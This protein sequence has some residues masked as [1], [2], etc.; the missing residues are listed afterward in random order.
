MTAFAKARVQ[1]QENS[2]VTFIVKA[3]IVLIV[4]YAGSK[5]LPALPTFAVGALW[6]A[7]SIVMTIGLT[8]HAV[9]RK[10]HRQYLL[11]S[12]GFVSRLINGWAFRLILAFVISAICVAGLFFEAPK[13]G[14]AEWCTV[15]L[16]I[17]VY[18]GVSTL[19]GKVIDKELEPVFQTSRK[20]LWS[21]LI[22]GALLC[23]VYAV[24]CF[25]QP[26][27]TYATAADAFL[28]A[29]QPFAQSPS[30]IMA[31]AGKLVALVDGLTVYALSRAGRF[32]HVWNRQPAR[33]LLAW[34]ARFQAS[35]PAARS[36]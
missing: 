30:A 17:P 24:I 16:A 36:N 8:Y 27:E 4:L 31:E 11:K 6:S 34:P 18:L 7:L 2:P 23:I 33:G 21:S 28:A 25:T 35:F 22:V 5:V 15:I 10:F 26:Q 13:W 12:D 19:L 20:A 1:L 9:I 3:V 14:V 29:K 32:G